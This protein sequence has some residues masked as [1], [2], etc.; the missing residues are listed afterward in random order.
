MIIYN[1]VTENL[2]IMVPQ[3]NFFLDGLLILSFR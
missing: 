2:R 1:S 3:V